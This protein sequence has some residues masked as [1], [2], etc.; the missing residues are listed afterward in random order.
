[1]SRDI[2]IDYRRY[3][4]KPGNTGRYIG[5]AACNAGFRAV[6]LYRIGVWFRKRRVRVIPG[7]IERIMHHACHCWISLGAE[8]GPGL[9]ITH[10]GEIV[11][12]GQTQIGANCDIRQNVTLGETSIKR[13]KQV[14]HSHGWGIMSRLAP[15][16]SSWD[17]CVW[18]RIR[19]WARIV[20]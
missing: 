7:V 17:R 3:S 19:L 14:A 1:M 15:V 20:S 4:Q 10:V 2:E 16:R 6:L 8:I 18:A 13:M 9:L 12:G 5:K 11:V